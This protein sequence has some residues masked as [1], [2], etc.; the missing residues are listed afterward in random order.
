[1]L[2]PGAV[3]FPLSFPWRVRTVLELAGHLMGRPPDAR[4]PIPPWC[5]LWDSELTR[6][7][8][9]SLTFQT[10]VLSSSLKIPARRLTFTPVEMVCVCVCVEGAQEG[11]E[12]GP[13]IHGVHE[14]VHSNRPF[15][16]PVISTGTSQCLHPEFEAP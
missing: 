14:P 8:R 15:P 3:G 13:F 6:N 9:E 12:W 11:R 1:M 5:C 2:S 16:C 4:V 7:L 10:V